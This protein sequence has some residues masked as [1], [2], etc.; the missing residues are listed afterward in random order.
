MMFK[1][2]IDEHG[3][4]NKPGER[5]EGFGWIEGDVTFE[6]NKTLSKGSYEYC[7][8]NIEG[9]EIHCGKSEEYPLFF[10]DKSIFGTHIHGLFHNDSFRTRFL[11]KIKPGYRGYSYD[12]Y[13]KRELEKLKNS[14]AEHIDVDKIIE[15][16]SC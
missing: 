9:Y 6:K 12:E 13:R 7:G 2:L 15:A 1:N 5:E 8:K 10:E 14:V 11:R 3:A 16:V 4:E